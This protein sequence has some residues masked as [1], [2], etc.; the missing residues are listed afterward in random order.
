MLRRS[1]CR[2]NK[3]GDNQ[4]DAELSIMTTIIPRGR[5]CR[6]RRGASNAADAR[7]CARFEFQPIREVLLQSCCR[8][9]HRQQSIQFMIAGSE[10]AAA[11]GPPFALDRRFRGGRLHFRSDTQIRSAK[12]LSVLRNRWIPNHRK[13]QATITLTARSDRWSALWPPRMH[14]RNPSMTPT[15]GLRE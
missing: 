2:W 15:I 1:C 7:R 9:S 14:Q 12:L 4:P 6:N 11:Q 5:L 8:C 3:G 13:K 10:P